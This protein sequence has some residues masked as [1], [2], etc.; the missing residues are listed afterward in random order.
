MTS[1][2]L[3]ELHRILTDVDAEQRQLDAELA[4]AEPDWQRKSS[5]YQRWDKGFLFKH[6][7]KTRFADL[8]EQSQI[9]REKLDELI[10]QRRLTRMPTEIE[11]ANELKPSLG[12]LFDAF[13]RLSGSICIWDTISTQ[14]TDQ[15]RERTLAKSNIE[16]TPVKFNVQQS[17]L[18]Q[19]E[20]KAPCLGNANGGDMFIYP[21]F[22]L[23]RVTRQAF[24]VIDCREVSIEFSPTNF[25][26]ESA[27]PT[28][29]QIVG[30]TWKY[31]NKN[32]SPDRRFS[33]NY[34]IPIV[35]YGQITLT[36]PTGL[37]EQYLISNCRAAEEFVAYWKKFKTTLSG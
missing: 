14:R 2:A 16:R 12:Q 8:Q 19:C 11:I 4:L 20:W 9:A 27:V 29:A 24:A 28:D 31:A 1:Q 21:G 35:L 30:H 6:I 26:E 15:Y 22:L 3:R 5:K 23:Y 34:Q 25:I 7:R 32:G 13:S 33:S 17:D 18:L 37:N 10:E 36:S